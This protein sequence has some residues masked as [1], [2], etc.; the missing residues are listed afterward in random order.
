MFSWTRSSGVS[1][2]VPYPSAC[3]FLFLKP[4]E[5]YSPS[6]VSHNSVP[7]ITIEVFSS[8]VAADPKS[9]LYLPKGCLD[10][11]P[12][13]ARIFCPREYPFQRDRS[14]QSRPNR[15]NS[16]HRAISWIHPVCKPCVR[17]GTSSLCSG[18]SEGCLLCSSS[19]SNRECCAGRQRHSGQEEE[20]LLL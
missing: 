14:S 11:F 20:R 13:R 6:T 19:W 15:A 17:P 9:V 3:T 10:K 4:C 5:L 2:S 18:S 8:T 16:E 7:Y 1:P 12:T